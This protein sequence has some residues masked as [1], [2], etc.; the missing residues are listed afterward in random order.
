MKLSLGQRLKNKTLLKKG[1]T[2]FMGCKAGSQGREGICMHVCVFNRKAP[3]D[4][5]SVDLNAE[6]EMTE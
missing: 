5:D 4:G 2:E 3:K 1:L 6:M